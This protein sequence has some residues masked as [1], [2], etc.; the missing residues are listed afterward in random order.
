MIKYGVAATAVLAALCA[1]ASAPI[2]SWCIAA[3]AA[4]ANATVGLPLRLMR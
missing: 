4:G 1:I 2:Q 3:T